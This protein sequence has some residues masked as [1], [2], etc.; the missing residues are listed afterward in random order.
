MV[1]RRKLAGETAPSEN[2]Q[3]QI[4]HQQ[5][6]LNE[7]ENHPLQ[8]GCESNLKDSKRTQEVH[9][10]STNIEETIGE[11]PRKH[12]RKQPSRNLPDL[13]QL[14]P[15]GQQTTFADLVRVHDQLHRMEVERS[16]KDES[17]P[18]NRS[19]TKTST[20]HNV[21]HKDHL[22]EAYEIC[23]L[24]KQQDK[25][26]VSTS[27]LETT[28]ADDVLP[29][30]VSHSV[31]VPALQLHGFQSSEKSNLTS[32]AD[33]MKV[34]GNITNNNKFFEKVNNS[35]NSRSSLEDFESEKVRISYFLEW[36][37]SIYI[38]RIK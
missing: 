35:R 16:G 7:N 10:S 22:K 11:S 21:K 8:S 15:K 13:D 36:L 3:K 19:L 34:S 6:H 5:I 18:P 20:S 32:F 28:S 27:A 1:T 37:L 12:R 9:S 14:M 29:S 2:L 24:Q 25:C 31:D 17:P 26:R 23:Q 4:S 38:H 30:N 33:E